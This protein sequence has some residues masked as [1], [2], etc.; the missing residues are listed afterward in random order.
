VTTPPRNDSEPNEEELPGQSPGGKRSRSS[1]ELE[2]TRPDA[3][4]PGTRPGTRP[5]RLAG[6]SRRHLRASQRPATTSRSCPLV[7]RLI[8]LETEYA[9]MVVDHEGL[10]RDSLPS[11]QLI[12]M[13]VCEAIRRDQPTVSG[14]YDHDQMFLANGGAVTFETHPALQSLPGGLIE[15]ATPEVRSPHELLACQR[16]IDELIADAAAEIGLAIDLR[17]LKNSADSVGHVYGCQENYEAEVATGVWL[18]VYRVFICL[19]WVMQITSL[20][21][22]L[23]VLAA[24]FSLVSCVQIARGQFWTLSREPRDLFDRVPGWVTAG[25]I[26]SLRIVHL[27]TA[28]V[29]R[30][31]GR[32]IAFRPQRKYL[33]AMLVSRVAMCGTGHIDQHGRYSMSAKAMAIDSVA[34]LGGYRGERPI[35]VYGHWLSQFCAK[36]FFSL[37]S[38]RQMFG[39]RQ[40]LQIG[41]SDSNLSDLAEYVK[42]GSISLMLDV[43]ES[44]QTANLPTLRRPLAALHRLA[45]DWDLIASVPTSHGELS[46]IE[47]QQTYLEA[48]EAFVQNTPKNWQ[49]ESRQV[50]ARWRELLDALTAYRK[51]A[52]DTTSAIGRIDWLT[53][54]WMVDQLEQPAEWAA[55]K[56]IDLRYHELSSQGY[57]AQLAEA[58]P[59]LRLVDEELISRRRRSPPPSSPA[60]RRGWMIREFAGSDEFLQTEWTYGMVGQ[61]RHRRRVEFAKSTFH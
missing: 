37:S 10:L 45:R 56:K 7:S 3:P 6:T 55:K 20:L 38:T 25:M 29:L 42:F 41:L 21:I 52:N 50:L 14:I 57:F 31:V 43:I 61:G 11:S 54:R 48:A 24:V 19:L 46:A 22:A 2:A 32:H 47:L 8:G 58:C 53:K 27:P 5:S 33:A 9:T 51:D 30:F 36:S 40:R 16:S 17:I 26:H 34:D 39:K 12:Y 15:I 49:G 18:G 35:F 23:P 4:P 1:R 13:Q 28:M 60:A 59:E 44:G